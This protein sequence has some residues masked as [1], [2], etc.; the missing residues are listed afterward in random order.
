MSATSRPGPI[1][2]RAEEEAAAAVAVRPPRALANTATRATADAA[3]PERRAPRDGAPQA[4]RAATRAAPAKPAAAAAV[5]AAPRRG[6][7]FAAEHVGLIVSA[8]LLAF[9]WVAPLTDYLTPRSGAGYALGIIGGSLMLLLLVYP[10][11]KRMESLRFLGSNKFWF[12][13]HMILGVAGPICIVYHCCYR[14]G[15]TNSNVALVSMLIVAGSG[16]I[17][18]YLY[19]RIHHGLYGHKVSLTELRTEAEQLKQRSDGISRVLPD[20]TARLDK[21]ELRISRGLWLVPKAVSAAALYYFGR[22]GM[23]RYVHRTLRSAAAT[24]RPIAWQRG[25]LTQSAERYAD[26]R[27][28]ASRRV[29]EF[30]SCERLFGLWHVLHVPLFGML[31]VAGIIHVIAV[32]VY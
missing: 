10:L 32:N 5:E 6:L 28:M 26:S 2:R 7:G 8:L 13:F 12:R 9:G 16:L 4:A 25:A 30:A 14:L 19:T 31:F 29:A 15:A 24:S 21:A 11:R 18:R 22:A 23:R 3:R 27:L 17:G 1:A 20:F